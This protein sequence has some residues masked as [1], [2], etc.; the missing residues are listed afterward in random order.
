MKWEGKVLAEEASGVLA[1]MPQG[2]VDLAVTSPPYDD[3]RK[4]EGY[5]FDARAVGE[6]LLRAVRPGGTV[7]WVTGDKVFRGNRSLTAFRQAIAFQEMGW[8]VWDVIIFV[9]KNYPFCRKNAYIS[10][11]EYIFVLRKKGGRETFNPI[12]VPTKNPGQ[13]VMRA[14]DKGADGV[15]KYAANVIRERRPRTNVWEYGVGSGQSAAEAAAFAHPAVFPE[16]LAGD[17]ILSWSDPGDLVLDPMCGSGTTLKMAAAYGRRW[18]GVDV[19]PRYAELAL[20]RARMAESRL[21]FPGGD[22]PSPEGSPEHRRMLPFDEE[23]P[24]GSPGGGS[25]HG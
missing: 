18:L 19:S 10:A 13:A 6:G 7:C 16:A 8:K 25:D 1:R 23:P 3:M 5:R 21:E 4:Y 2:I 12:T 9:K 22:S 24:R 20:R 14:Y 17:C 11:H 15:N